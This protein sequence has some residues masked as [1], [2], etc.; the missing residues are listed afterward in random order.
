MRNF[1]LCDFCQSIGN[2]VL[3]R[4]DQVSIM[5][6]LAR[7]DVS[8]MEIAYNDTW[9]E[10][11]FWSVLNIAASECKDW[12]TLTCNHLY[13]LADAMMGHVDAVTVTQLIKILQAA[14]QVVPSHVLGVHECVQ[15]MLDYW[16]NQ[17]TSTADR[18]F[19]LSPNCESH[20][21]RQSSKKRISTCLS[22]TGAEGFDWRGWWMLQSVQDYA[23]AFQRQAI[24]MTSI[25]LKPASAKP[26]TS[27]QILRYKGL[28]IRVT[29]TCLPDEKYRM[30]VDWVGGI[31]RLNLNHCGLIT[32]KAFTA[33]PAI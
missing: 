21:I 11:R 33:Q 5:L 10:Q 6:G 15:W 29:C 4:M 3:H 20:A 26:N 31:S 12:K 25:D 9:P 1:D 18:Y 24:T 16:R 2:E 30:R 27:V 14:G 22:P 13:P 28:C 32:E 19:L 17:R 8:R 7:R 23:I